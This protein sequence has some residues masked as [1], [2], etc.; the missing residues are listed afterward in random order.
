MNRPAVSILLVSWN[1]RSLT[2]ACLEALPGSVDDDLRYETI[3]VDNGSRDGSA[4]ALRRRGDVLLVEN[5]ENRGYAAAVNQAYARARGELVLLLNSDVR[6]GPAALSA[7]VSFLL[8]HPDEAGVAPRYLNPDGTP[9]S[10]YYQLPTFATALALATGLRVIPPF[11]RRFRAYRMLDED[12]SRPRPVPQPSASCLLLRRRH[13]PEGDLLD[14]G[15]PI[16]FNDVALARSL[17]AVGRRLWMT[18][19][20]TARHELGAST[21]LLGPALARHHLGALVRYLAATEPRTRLLLFRG[22]VL[23]DR[24]LRRLPRRP[25]MLPLRD[26]GPALRGD[27]GPLP[28]LD[29]RGWVVYL[30]GIAWARQRHRQ[31]ELA[32]H[33]TKER[34]VLFLEP[35]AIA[36]S[37]RLDVE[38]LT[39]SLWRAAPPAPFPLGRF[40]SA[41]NRLNRRLAARSLRRWLDRH[42][43][44]RL[45]LVDEDLSE[46]LIGR[47]GEHGVV[48]DAA[49]LDW[50]FTRSWNRP[51]VRRALDRAVARADLV[52]ASSRALVEPLALG[53]KEVLALP[54]AC[55]PDHF[56]PD[57]LEAEALGPIPRPRLGYVGALD[58]RAFD[59]ELVA[60][61]AHSRSDWSLVLVG[62]STNPVRRR[63]AGLANVHLLGPVPYTD[64]PAVLRGFEVCL[65][66]YRLT[67]RARYVHP[68]KLYEY[69]AAGKPVVST[70]LPAL[71]DAAVPCRMARTAHEFAD[72]IDDTLREA[73]SKE[74]ALL[75]RSAATANTWA[76]RGEELL[77]L[78]DGLGRRAA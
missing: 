46:P 50:T 56:T 38:R 33:L 70:P 28:N 21:R 63:L 1:T 42:P 4:E 49:D 47:L 25:G 72:A 2:L 52:L 37:L 65:I 75:R 68:K 44:P 60:D 55:D 13:L 74:L 11:R 29:S 77:A 45:L 61:L 43:G 9:Q 71:A 19:A 57:G 26:L 41:A 67:G 40:F 15:Y 78:L 59:A 32:Q 20:A 6:L 22:L 7:L 64:V 12:F 3:V 16:F 34:R 31:H 73:G 36:P 14:E 39:P 48:Y 27:P 30:S 35:P 10:H 5:A 24:L 62:P 54:N 76:M 23:F 69:L 51:H 58:E 53:G 66:P 17:A 8:T 18:P